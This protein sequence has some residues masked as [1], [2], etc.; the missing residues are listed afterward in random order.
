MKREKQGPQPRRKRHLLSGM[1]AHGLKP[2]VKPLP[3]RAGT[4]GLR[5]GKVENEH[6]VRRGSS[7]GSSGAGGKR[8]G[9]SGQGPVLFLWE[10]QQ[11]Q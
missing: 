10:E 6:S 2:P 4:E 7:S 11:E 9:L 1:G 8:G 3:G 5:L